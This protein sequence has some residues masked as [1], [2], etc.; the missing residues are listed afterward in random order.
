MHEDLRALVAPAGMRV[1]FSS[2]SYG[3]LEPIIQKHIRVSIMNAS[4]NG[5]VWAGDSSPDRVP[6]G[7]ARNMSANT[8][9]EYADV[10][11]GVLWCDS[12]IRTESG[13]FTRLLRT[14]DVYGLDFV[15]GVYHQRLPP[16][17]PLIYIRLEKYSNCLDYPPNQI[18]PVDGCGFGICYTSTRML[19]AIAKLPQFDAKAGGWFPDTRDTGGYGEDLSFC[20]LAHEA[21]FQLYVDTG[22]QVGHQGDPKIILES[23]FRSAS[24]TEIKPAVHD[25]GGKVS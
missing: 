25:W 14:A 12:D 8:A 21:G 9:V 5:V 1:L 17:L 19:Q 3:H 15:T 24:H 16:Y 2:Q 22:V 18:A 20:T 13:T 4:A 23:D 10:I 11:D 7:L 6:Y